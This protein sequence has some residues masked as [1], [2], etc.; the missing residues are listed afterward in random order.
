[1]ASSILRG[2]LFGAFGADLCPILV[3]TPFEDGLDVV[4]DDDRDL[5][6]VTAFRGGGLVY[7]VRG[8]VFLM[9]ERVV[10]GMNIFGSEGLRYHG[11]GR[12][13]GE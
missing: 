4:L 8:R 2:R 11:Q 3:C 9:A 12:K 1:M 13:T 5:S 7:T 6:C 10:A